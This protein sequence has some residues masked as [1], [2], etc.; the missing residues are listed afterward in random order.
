MG[1]ITC[2]LQQKNVGAKVRRECMYPKPAKEVGQVR[3]AIMQWE[4]K[5]KAM[6]SELGGDAQNPDLW[7]MSALLEMCPMLMRLDE[8]GENFANL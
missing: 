7:R 2:K 4:E 1:D 6:T 5:W 3:L 8:I